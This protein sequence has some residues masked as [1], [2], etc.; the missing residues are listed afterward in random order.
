M[1][2]PRPADQAVVCSSCGA[3]RRR[4]R[5]QP[6]SRKGTTRPWRGIAIV[7]SHQPL[8]RGRVVDIVPRRQLEEIEAKRGCLLAR[9]CGDGAG[10]P[11]DVGK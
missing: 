10:A 1:A 11:C 9:A 3:G 2:R 6:K 5:I 8:Q 7:L 4:E